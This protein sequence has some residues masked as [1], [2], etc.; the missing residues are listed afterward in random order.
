MIFLALLG[1]IYFFFVKVWSYTLD[2][3]WK[4]IF[5][6]KIH[7]SM[8]FSSNFLKR[9]SFQKGLHRQM[10]FLVSSGK[11]VFFS[12]KHDIFFLGREWGRPFPGNTWKYD[13]FCVHVRVL[14]TWHHTALSKKSQRWS[15]PAKIHLNVI[16]VLDWHP[17]K[18]SSHSL[19]LH[20]DLCRCFHGLLSSE[21]KQEA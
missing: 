17:R 20:G 7:E 11:I 5:L 13:I 1:K 9:L 19:Y 14:E 18:S 15:Y 4:M 2:G 3:K 21:E 12:Q 16:D 6:K 8:M 10:I